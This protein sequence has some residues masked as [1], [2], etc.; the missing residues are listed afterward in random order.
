MQLNKSAIYI[1][2]IFFDIDL[3]CFF[4]IVFDKQFQL[5]KINLNH[6]ITIM[7]QRSYKCEITKDS[8]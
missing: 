3:Y 2:S 1:F 7:R 6:K 8:G 5:G 4:I